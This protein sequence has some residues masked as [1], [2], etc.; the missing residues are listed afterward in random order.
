MGKKVLLADD[1][2]TIQKLVEMAF[3]DTDFILVS[4]SDGQQAVDRLAEVSPDIILADAIMPHLD[5]YEVCR[6]VK[7]KPE[8]AQIPVV[9]LTGRFQPFDQAKAE[10]VHI[11][12]RVVKPFV[13]EQLVDLINRLTGKGDSAPVEDAEA[14]AAATSEEPA[15]VDAFKDDDHDET[16]MLDSSMSFESEADQ[17]VTHS[18]RPNE[19]DSHSTIRV[20]PDELQA[21]L[22]DK[23]A[24]EAEA[25]AAGDVGDSLDDVELGDVEIEDLDQIE[26]LE[27]VDELAELGVEELD[28]ADVLEVDELEEIEEESPTG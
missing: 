2:I 11:D 13:Q 3:A 26:D 17:E 16:L 18:D 9:L 28:D 5:G 25:A 23:Q 20:N 24:A 19:Y 8:F 7:S 15:V 6:Y 4:V 1:S 22:R 12:G 21:Y 14:G 10:E 27:Q